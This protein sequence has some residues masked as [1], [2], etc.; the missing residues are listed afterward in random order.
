MKTGIVLK[1]LLFTGPTV[2]PARIDF[3]DGLNLLYGASNTGKSFALKALDFALGGSKAL[4][5]ITERDG[6]DRIWLA[7]IANGENVTLARAL[8]GG[9]FQLWPG[10]VMEAVQGVTPRSLGAKHDAGSDDNVSQFLLAATGLT[11]RL[12]AVDANGKKRS[13]SFRDLVR[14][15]LIDETTIQSEEAPLNS[16][17]A[18]F[19]TAERSVFKLLLTGVDDSAIV[20]IIDRK[21]FKTSTA[22]KI[23]MLEDMLQAVQTELDNSFPDPDELA[24]QEEKLEKTLADAQ[25]DVEAA[26]TSIRTYLEHRATESAALELAQERLN[27]VEHN[28]ARFGQLDEIYQ[29]DV[30]RLEALE[31]VGFLLSLGGDRECPLCGAS[32]E[33]QRG[34]HAL[35]DVEKVRAASL[36]EI[37]K[38]KQQRADLQRTVN[39]L[40]AETKRLQEA[41]PLMRA[42]LEVAELALAR[43]APNANMVRRRLSE[44]TEV[45]DSVKRGRS[46]VD[47]R[48]SLQ[49]RK[50]ELEALR[51]AGKADKPKLG[52]GGTVA[53]DFAQTVSQVLK[54][55]HFPGDL[56]VSFDDTAYDLRIDGKLRRDNGKG[57]RAITHAAFKVALLIFCHDRGLPHPGFLVLDTPLLTYRDPMDPKAGVLTE[58]E[59][60]LA[61]TSLKQYFFDHL[62]TLKHV[63]QFIVI[64]NVDPPAN[65]ESI[66][67][68]E[69]FRGTAGSGRNGLFAN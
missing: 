40:G 38:I 35:D 34:E 27:E 51:P 14:F 54:A 5:D 22:A 63:G 31:E 20:E 50:I 68:I 55:W 69:I 58:D 60:Q 24:E 17:Q 56:H 36:I 48:T 9:N 47:Q 44:I 28:L 57:V 65:I 53:H 21:T 37:V 45:R 6:Y 18:M 67:N 62:A 49:N 8:A 43:L 30:E 46:L 23:E 7:V 19:A 2:S 11:E 1:H 25:A 52:V 13:L 39:E 64:E 10:L 4:P 42:R 66:A 32:P 61:K 41:M 15:S 26:Q 59:Q 33:A 12:I 16:G 3:D 29:S